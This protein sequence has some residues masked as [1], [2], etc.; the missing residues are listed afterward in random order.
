[1]STAVR[2]LRA[3]TLGRLSRDAAR[4]RPP[5]RSGTGQNLRGGRAFGARQQGGSGSHCQARVHAAPH[6]PRERRRC[7]PQSCR[8][9]MPNVR[10]VDRQER[11]AGSR[12]TRKV[13]EGRREHKR[14]IRQPRPCT[15]GGLRTSSSRSPS[16]CSLAT[17]DGVRICRCTQRWFGSLGWL[18]P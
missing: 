1:M 4:G 8:G 13:L 2:R 5:R 3:S 15:V 16:S 14:S 18:S 6:S 11:S 12:R 17:V 10:R 9:R 7:P